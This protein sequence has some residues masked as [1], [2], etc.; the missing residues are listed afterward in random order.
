MNKE[1]A[2]L[3]EPYNN[4]EINRL[5]EVF[6]IKT[7]RRMGWWL[8]KEGYKYIT[9][10]SNGK[11]Q[12]K[13]IHR[14][15]AITFIPNPYQL[16][17]VDHIN[18]KKLD[19]DIENLRWCSISEN[20]IN[21][22]PERFKYGTPGVT[23]SKCKTKFNVNLYRGGKKKWLGCYALLDEAIEVYKTGVRDWIDD[24]KTTVIF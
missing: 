6:N 14:L 7:C 11:K 10:Y 1:F 5:G 18:R 24:N 4:Y 13:N 23:D 20:N 3:P 19:N 15:L 12:N 9:L 21:T 16:P 17:I 2:I 22:D 8:N